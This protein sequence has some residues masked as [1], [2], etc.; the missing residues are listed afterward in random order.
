MDVLEV[1][2]SSHSDPQYNEYLS[3]LE[4]LVH[5][6]QPG[7][8]YFKPLFKQPCPTGDILSA[9]LGQNHQ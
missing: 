3:D 4:E 8:I 1:A 7:F 2:T 5:F 6:A 9:Q